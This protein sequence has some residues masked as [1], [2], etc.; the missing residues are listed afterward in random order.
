MMVRHPTLR[1][2]IINA[3]LGS[4]LLLGGCAHVN[5]DLSK[6]PDVELGEVALYPTLQA[7]AGAPIVR[8]N[9]VQILLNGDE[10]FPAVVTA[11]R[12]ARTS[13]T[14]AQYFFEEGP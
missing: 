14:Y 11:I 6:L 13:I 8:G 3:I 9:D 1:R 10:I 5:A 4:V 12:S 7:Y 2:R